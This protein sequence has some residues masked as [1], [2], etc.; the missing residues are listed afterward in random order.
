[1]PEIPET[2]LKF[3]GDDYKK[4]GETESNVVARTDEEA[5]HSW[6]CYRTDRQ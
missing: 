6:W 5:G 1:M 4:E 2:S 3:A